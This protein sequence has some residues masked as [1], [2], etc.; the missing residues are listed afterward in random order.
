MKNKD[1]EKIEKQMARAIIL[2]CRG[3]VISN[4]RKKYRLN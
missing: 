3:R 2:I 1:A 4:C